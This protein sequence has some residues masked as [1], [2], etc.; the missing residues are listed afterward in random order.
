[1]DVIEGRRR[2]IIESVQPNIDGGRFPVKR[3]QGDKVFVEADIFTDGHDAIHSLLKYKH[4]GAS[5][6]EEITMQPMGNDRWRADFTVQT[7][8]RCSYVIVAWVDAFL[9]W[10]HDLVKRTQNEDIKA[11]LAQGAAL[12]IQTSAL[13]TD[14]EHASRLEAWASAM[15]GTKPLEHRRRLAL[16]PEIEKLML[17][18]AHR[19]FASTS[20][21]HYVIVEPPIARF[22]AW[23]EFF[24]RSTSD[25]HSAHGTLKDA[26]SRLEYIAQMG[27]DVVYLPPC[28]PIGLSN[29][30]GKNNALRAQDNDPGSPWAIGAKVGGHKDIHPEL[31]TLA[32]FRSFVAKAKSFSLHLALD[33]AF[34][35]SPDHPYVQEFPAWFSWTVDGTI[36]YAENPPK[37]YQDIYPFNFESEQW[38]PLWNELKS[39][40][41][42]WI[43]QG[44]T[45]FRVDNPHTKPF[46]FWEWLIDNVKNRHPEVIFLAEAFARP[47]IMYR[48]AKLGF[49]QS[50]TYFCWRNT[51][52]ELIRY[53]EELTQT[54]VNEYF[55]PNL[56][57]N[58]PDI[59]TE[60]LQLGGRPAFMTRLVL[61][62][63]LGASY[64]IYGPAFE[65]CENRA[66]EPGSEEY[67]DSEKYQITHW[68]INS[69]HSLREYIS[70]INKIRREHAALQTD[71]TLRFY[72]IDNDHLLCFAKFSPD[73]ID[74]ILVVVNLDPH[75]TQT[76]WIDLPLAELNLDACHGYE[77]HELLSDTRL[78][79]YGARNYVELDPQKSPAN[80]FRLRR[81]IRS[82]QDFEYFL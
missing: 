80:I 38:Q 48:L 1:M 44:V 73:S 46:A 4:S 24:P 3:I 16:D 36:Q 71:S 32:D 78:L 10:R 76:G 53:F 22:G 55:R 9:S 12:I 33:I 51:K 8:G 13:A 49:S 23:Y 75:H 59:L 27:F 35:C 65:L 58:T 18:Y 39:I 43:E 77:V 74:V 17:R 47:K 7:L 30:K 64:G 11:A 34:Q 28:Y 67:L 60:Y 70:A 6:W 61:A 50:Y 72:P 20:E 82:E 66:R 25:A 69:T 21:Q 37:K 54:Q 29:R 14:E 26:E 15:T 2:T 5:E 19:N 41:E 81:R 68:D 63:T 42:F 31:G 57:P 52:W 62:A 79:W 45:I 56:W 40:V